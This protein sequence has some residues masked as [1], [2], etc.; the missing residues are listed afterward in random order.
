MTEHLTSK[1][2]LEHLRYYADHDESAPTWLVRSAADEIERL[3]KLLRRA[4]DVMTLKASGTLANNLCPDH[5]DKQTGKPCLS[6][7]IER[8]QRLLDRALQ[9]NND[10][11][12]LM[13]QW[14][15]NA[16]A[17]RTAQPPTAPTSNGCGCERACA[18]ELGYK[19]QGECSRD[20]GE[21][22]EPLRAADVV[23]DREFYWMKGVPGAHCK[24]RVD[25]VR[26]EPNG[27]VRVFTTTLE[28]TGL[29]AVGD[30]CW[31][32]MSRFLEACTA[33]SE[34]DA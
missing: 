13:Q 22:K 4:N 15:D 7:E 29:N 26:H 12:C 10:L 2:L 19:I 17:P 28:A 20:A 3:N 9:R 6:C 34:N 18:K 14:M 24:V 23:P 31:N 5:R 30:K 25:E 21:T 16:N 1:D 8:L 32:D 33:V 27:D 11:E